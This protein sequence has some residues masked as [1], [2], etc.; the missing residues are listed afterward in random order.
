M[1]A[2]T[3][4]DLLL[5]GIAAA[6]D[7]MFAVNGSQHIIYWSERAKRLLGHD[8]SEVVG[9]PCY[10]VVRGQRTAGNATPFAFCTRDCSTIQAVRAGKG[11][12]A[13]DVACPRSDDERRW[14]NMTI[15]PLGPPLVDQPVAVHLVRDVT[16][17]RRAEALAG[18]LASVFRAYQDQ[19]GA[20]A[21]VPEPGASSG[22]DAIPPLTSRERA[23]LNC[24]SS[25]DD[26]RRT[27]ARLGIS[28]GTVRNHLS[29]LMRKLGVHT[30]VEALLRATRLGLVG[31]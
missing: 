12:P 7:G 4:T 8:A 21:P 18:R 5:E 29:A 31:P 28:T 6:E 9:L 25:G 19:G 10:E 27:A 15:L 1:K 30:R 17:R 16:D 14:L 13:Y 24:L 2:Q 23:V 20:L 22:A 26:T 11:V 3:P